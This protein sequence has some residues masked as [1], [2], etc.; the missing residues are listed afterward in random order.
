MHGRIL[1]LQG[2][3]VRL[4]DRIASKVCE[5][6]RLANSVDICLRGQSESKAHIEVDVFMYMGRKWRGYAIKVRGE[7]EV[8]EES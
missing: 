4:T 6:T 3:V 1:S 5:D 7:M 8:E 2:A